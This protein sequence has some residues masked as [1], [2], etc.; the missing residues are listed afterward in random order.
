MNIDWKG[1][2]EIPHEYVVPEDKC[3]PFLS[4]DIYLKIYLENLK[5]P[6]RWTTIAKRIE[7]GQ[8]V[9]N[10]IIKNK[11]LEIER[12]IKDYKNYNDIIRKIPFELENIIEYLQNKEVSFENQDEW[13]G[14]LY[15]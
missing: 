10:I 6:H 8:N 2:H 4:L 13:R 11:A 14:F 7:I 15:E 5:T 9:N 3:P 12:K 1:F